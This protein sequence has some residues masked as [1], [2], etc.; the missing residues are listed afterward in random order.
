MK[1]AYKFQYTLKNIID[2]FCSLLGFA[3][4]IPLF[5]IISIIIKLNSK[6]PI[7]F[8]Q[9]R[10]GKNEKIF[11]LYKFRMQEFRDKNGNLLSDKKRLTKIGKFLRRFSLDK[12]P[13]L[14]NVLKGDMSLVG[15]R[16]L[17]IGYIEL[18]T[19]EQSRRH[20]SLPGLTGWTQVRGRNALT[21]EEKFALDT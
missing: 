13:E 1:I 3:I 4:L 14:W 15:P 16:P 5:L 10:L 2:I 19:P 8:I 6:G 11:S 21:W 20:L 9:S 18:Y 7:F 12:P 17:L